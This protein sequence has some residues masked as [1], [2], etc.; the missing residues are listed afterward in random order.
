MRIPSNA[1][2]RYTADRFGSQ[3]PEHV[4]PRATAAPQV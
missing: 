2:D 3:A 1:A 4:D